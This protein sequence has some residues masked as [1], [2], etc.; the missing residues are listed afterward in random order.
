MIRNRVAIVAL[1]VLAIAF[2][3]AGVV[4]RGAPVAVDFPIPS[5]HS[6]GM[7][8]VPVWMGLRIVLWQIPHFGGWPYAPM[9]GAFVVPLWPIAVLLSALGYVAFRWRHRHNSSPSLSYHAGNER[10][11]PAS[12]HSPSS[13]TL[14]PRQAPENKPRR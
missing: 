1:V 14:A 3:W 2:G 4:I 12:T 11:A 13:P 10:G 5:G 7:S 6:T 9:V 8:L